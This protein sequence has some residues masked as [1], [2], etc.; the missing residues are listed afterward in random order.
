MKLVWILSLLASLPA[1]SV[2]ADGPVPVVAP[3]TPPALSATSPSP[4]PSPTVQ[5]ITPAEAKNLLREFEKA[6]RSELKALEFRQKFELKELKASQTARR[7]EWEAKE[8]IALHDFLNQHKKG[9]E[10]RAYTADRRVRHTA[11]LQLLNEELTQRTQNQQVRTNSVKS[12]QAS[13]LKE[14]QDSVARGERPP[15]RFWPQAGI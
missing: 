2:Q 11:F 6:Q 15:A 8:S 7:K 1:A 4:S 9:D 13:R 14:F 10:I 12:D 3:S 5:K